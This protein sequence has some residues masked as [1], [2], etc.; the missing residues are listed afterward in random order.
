MRRPKQGHAS[1]SSQADDRED[2]PWQPQGRLGQVAVAFTW[3][4]AAAGA[5]VAAFGTADAIAS[6][7]YDRPL[8]GVVEVTE[9]ALVVIIAMTQPFIVMSGSHITLDLFAPRDGSIAAFLRRA[10]SLATALLT[11]GLITFTAWSTFAASWAVREQT[12]GVVR[13]PVYPVKFLL[14]LGMAMTCLVI[15]AQIAGDLRNAIPRLA[16]RK[17]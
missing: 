17:R 12:D 14:V 7:V 8:A 15:I 4:A 5:V 13:L 9:L 3:V 11:Y 2:L 16:A 1:V 10:L 6:F